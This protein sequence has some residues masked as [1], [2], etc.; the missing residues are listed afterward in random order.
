[1]SPTSTR[2][3]TTVTG[4]SANATPTPTATAQGLPK[5]NPC[6]TIGLT[7]AQM[8]SISGLAVINR[9]SKGFACSFTGVFD[10]MGRGDSV[11]L[12]QIAHAGAAD[13]YVRNVFPS[14]AVAGTCIWD[15]A[16]HTRFH[17]AQGSPQLPVFVGTVVSAGSGHLWESVTNTVTAAKRDAAVAAIETYTTTH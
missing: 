1:M 8:S 11:S 9:Q 10:S 13:T 2:P 3:S 12:Q 7:A 5:A 17:C 4:S 14:F 16:P 6:A 15:D